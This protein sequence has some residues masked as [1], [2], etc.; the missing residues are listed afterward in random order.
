[1][2]RNEISDFQQAIS[3]ALSRFRPQVWFSKLS[4]L[5]FHFAHMRFDKPSSSFNVISNRAL[6]VSLSWLAFLPNNAT[7]WWLKPQ[8]ICKGGTPMP[9]SLTGPRWDVSY[10]NLVRAHTFKQSKHHKREQCHVQLTGST[11]VCTWRTFYHSR[12]QAKD[13]HAKIFYVT[14]LI[15]HS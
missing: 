6:I 2:A 4:T 15:L 1:M 11:S 3:H 13:T 8:R 7:L 5:H 10:L 14:E 12:C 9:F